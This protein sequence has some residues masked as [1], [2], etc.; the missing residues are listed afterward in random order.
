[1]GVGDDVAGG[2]V[3]SVCTVVC[4]I[5]QDTQ[6][7]VIDA[8]TGIFVGEA[9]FPTTMLAYIRFFAML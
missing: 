9:I 3:H 7:D 4:F 2:A 6:D 5:E 8:E 1:M